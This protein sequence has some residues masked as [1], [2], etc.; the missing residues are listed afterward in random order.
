MK[1][2]EVADTETFGL[3]GKLMIHN[4]GI[5]GRKIT[6]ATVI[7]KHMWHL[8]T[9]MLCCWDSTLQDWSSIPKKAT[10]TKLKN[11]IIAY[12][13]CKVYNKQYTIFNQN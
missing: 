11:W 12:K 13:Y 1:S 7:W 10:C 4:N 9:A 3:T 2:M 5:Q 6:K 8:E